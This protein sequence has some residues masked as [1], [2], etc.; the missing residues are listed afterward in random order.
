MGKSTGIKISSIRK[1]DGKDLGNCEICGKPATHHH[2]ASKAT[3]FR[4]DDG[5]HYLSNVSAGTY[6]H[7]ECLAVAYENPIDVTDWPRR[8]NLRVVPD[9]IFSS[10]SQYEQS[11]SRLGR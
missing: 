8:N 1:T 5:T 10:L 3:V 11:V 6:G 4:T 2:F 7:H 9:S